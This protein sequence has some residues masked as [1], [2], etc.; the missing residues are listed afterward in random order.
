MIDIEKEA[1]EIEEGEQ[2]KDEGDE[3]IKPAE[4][5]GIILFI[6]LYFPLYFNGR[7]LS[8]LSK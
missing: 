6:V 8:W 2:V 5:E 1:K 4:L 3:D 7:Y